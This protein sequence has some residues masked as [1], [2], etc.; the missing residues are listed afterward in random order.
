[1]YTYTGE[2]FVVVLLYYSIV[3]LTVRSSPFAQVL[4]GTEE[5]QLVDRGRYQIVPLL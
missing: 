1:M 5:H 3:F 4:V 2:Q